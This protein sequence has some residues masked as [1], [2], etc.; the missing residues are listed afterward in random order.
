VNIL[1]TGGCGF[2]GSNFVRYLRRNRPSWKLVN[3]D[4]LTYA[5]Q[6][7]N[8]RELESDPNHVFVQGDIAD[9]AKVEALFDRHDF[10]A[11]VHLAAESHVDRSIVD[12]ERFTETNIVGTHALLEVARKRLLRRFVQVSTDEVYGSLGPSGLFTERSPLQP[13]SPYSA[14]KAA[15]DLLALSYATTFGLDV[16]IT[17]SCNNYGP[18]QFPEKLIPLAITQ[19]LR[20]EP[21]PLYGDGLNVRDWLHVEDHCAALCVI[22]E[23]GRS[24]EVYNVG[25]RQERTN[26]ETLRTLLRLLGKPESLIQRVADRLGHDLRYAIDASKL[27]NEL[28]W[29]ARISWEQGMAETVSWYEQHEAWWKPL[30]ERWHPVR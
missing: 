24:G 9:K 19:A 3:L 20:D 6:R 15:A 11:I 29:S 13:S 1:V 8:V 12:P 27:T 14:S 23:K 28:G 5:G 30:R 21:V 10:E 4:K 25:A 18:F 16:V 2:I 7:E 22:L 17:R 26:L